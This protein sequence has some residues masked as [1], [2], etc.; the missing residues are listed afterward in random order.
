[1]PQKK[2]LNKM[3][4]GKKREREKQAKLEER[5][6]G[7]KC[8][9]CGGWVP[10]SEFIGTKHRNHCPSCL[11]SKHVDLE[12][13]GDRKSTCQ[14]GM[15]P[16]G[17]TF[18]QEGIDRYGSQRQ[19]ELIVIHWC[20]NANCG[21]ISINRIAGDDNPETILRVF[22]ESQAPDPNLKKA[23]NNDNIRLLTRDSEKQIRTQLFGK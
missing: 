5:K 16:I 18:K 4:R 19:G 23:L 12:E 22:E 21:K 3:Q 11:W 14:A 2:R 15:K 7:F 6:G 20:T 9:H 10:L 1:M 8:T 17:L 13:P